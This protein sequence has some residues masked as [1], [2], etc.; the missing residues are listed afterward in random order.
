VAFSQVIRIVP[1]DDL[2]RLPETM[3]RG[4]RGIALRPL[5]PAT[6]SA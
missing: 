3:T 5:A 1:Q 4:L 2:R 6:G